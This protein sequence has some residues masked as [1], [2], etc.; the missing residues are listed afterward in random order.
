MTARRVILPAVVAVG[1][2]GILIALGTWQLERKSW[3]EEL[4]AT[5]NSRLAAPPTNL[6]A[7]ERWQRLDAAKDE[8]TRVEFPATFVPGEEA[9]VYASGSGLRPDIKE[10]GYWVFSPARLS[11]GSVVVV[12]RG[13]VPEGRQD[14][15]TR[16]DGEPDGVVDIVGV[17]RWTEPR[18]SFT[19]NDEPSKSLR[20]ARDPAA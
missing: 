16:P 4:I 18:G 3:K 12:N 2:L 11:G 5:L 8:F 1:A 19:P 9:F 7:R 17:M 13:F 15:K 6:P 14:A 10:P 20:F